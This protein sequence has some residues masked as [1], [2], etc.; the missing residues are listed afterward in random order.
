VIGRTLAVLIDQ[1]I[2]IVHDYPRAERGDLNRHRPS[3]PLAG[4][5][6]YS[7]PPVQRFIG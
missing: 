3:Q 5:G 2:A 4:A 1:A 6:D 7:D